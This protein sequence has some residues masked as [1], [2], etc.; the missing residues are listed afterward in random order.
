MGKLIP[1]AFLC[2]LQ[3]F[4][5][6]GG[7]RA[8]VE[9]RNS[10]LAL[11]GEIIFPRLSCFALQLLRAAGTCGCRTPCFEAKIRQTRCRRSLGIRCAVRSVRACAD[12]HG[13]AGR[14][15]A[16]GRLSWGR[17][18]ALFNAL[19]NF[20]RQRNSCFSTLGRGFVGRACLSSRSSGSPGDV[21]S[22]ACGH[23]RPE[24]TSD[25]KYFRAGPVSVQRVPGQTGG[26]GTRGKVNAGQKQKRRQTAVRN[27]SFLDLS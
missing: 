1:R 5:K 23:E 7:E 22:P 2:S 4:I 15:G 12:V 21:R 8:K 13:C 6:N 24:F 3:L 9:G 16:G 26:R 19:G 11:P 17:G 18:R 27:R 20:R 25:A 10:A 14:A